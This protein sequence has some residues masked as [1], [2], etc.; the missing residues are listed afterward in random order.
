MAAMRAAN[1]RVYEADNA[2]SDGIQNV[3]ARLA[4]AGDGRPRLTFD[5]ACA[6][7][8]SEFES[9]VWAQDRDGK[10]L[11]TV[12]TISMS[13]HLPHHFK[14]T[15]M[16]RFLEVLQ[17]HGPVLHPEDIEQLLRS[18]IDRLHSKRSHL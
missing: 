15:H 6:N 17:S 4:V 8:I 13:V 12:A 1:L 16:S 3:K 10:A 14:G 2:V 18:L 9:Y 5:P 7:T 11:P